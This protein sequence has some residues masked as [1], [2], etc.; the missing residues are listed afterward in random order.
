MIITRMKNLLL[1]VV[2]LLTGV[3]AQAQFKGEITQ[4]PTTDYSAK[5]AEFKLSEVAT[6]LGTDAATLSAAIKTYIEAETPDPI[7]FYAV[8]G[9]QDTPW[10]AATE[11]DAHGFWVNAEGV[12]VG[13]GDNAKF[14]ISPNIEGAADDIF[15]FYCG[16]MPEKMQAGDKGTATIKLKFNDKEATFALTLNVIDKPAFDVPD[17]TLKWADLT[18]VGQ[19]EKV[20]EQHPRG[21]YS[22][23]EVKVSVKDA[24]TLLGITNKEGMAEN[25]G[26]VLYTTWYNTA[27]VEQGGGMKKDSLTNTPTG[28]GHGFWFRPVDNAQGEKDGEVSAAGWGDVDKFYLNNFTYNAVDDTLAVTLGQYPGSCKDNETWFANVYIVYG[29]QAYLIKY[30]LKLIEKE[31]GNG[32]AD[33]EK[34]GEGSTVVEAEPNSTYT[35][36]QVSIDV[37]TIAAALGCETSALGVIVLDDKDNFGSSTANNGGWWLSSAGT[38]VAWG[39]GSV[40]FIEPPTANDWSVVNVGQFPDALNVGDEVS[41]TL[42]F[43]NGTKY[44]PFTITLKIVEPQKQEFNFESVASRTFAVQQLLNNEYT[45]SEIGNIAVEDIEALLGTSA[46]VLYALLPDSVAAIKGDYTKEWNCDPNPGFWMSKEGHKTT[47]GNSS[48][49][50]VVYADGK[51][52]GCQMPNQ[53]AVGDVW[54]APLFLVNEETNKMITV[55]IQISFVETLEQKEKVGEETVWLP[56]QEGM[57]VDIDLAKAAQALGVTT[58]DLLKAENKYLRGMANGTYG[59]GKSCEDGLSFGN[60]GNYDGYGNIFFTIKK[61]GDKFIVETA[62]NDPVAEDFLVDA[63]FCFEV[64]NKQ[65]V[66]YVKLASKAQYEKRETGIS[67]IKTDVKDA[68]IF[69]IQGRQVKVAK[70]GLYI[71]NGK[72]VVIK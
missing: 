6:T 4:Y 37:E 20:I 71:I 23:D 10:T 32:L 2:C 9:D 21:D 41:A 7:L 3:Q 16:Q 39:A 47:W 42:N 58:D 67:T 66:Y 43:V 49:M 11:A 59:E 57:S 36:K 26:K 44:Y 51:F 13:W 53:P 50:G 25:I 68:R 19:Q 14:F 69:D 8:V 5:A 12:P 46:P 24:L 62:S 15:A 54:K 48:Y 31:Q 27:D 30:T 64:S 18:I 38:T 72:K 60:D 63:Q 17:P 33:Y 55:N 35:A 34:V 45:M 40:F 29:T 65:Y 56:V 70:K 1:A 22:G 61:D 52:Q 28:E